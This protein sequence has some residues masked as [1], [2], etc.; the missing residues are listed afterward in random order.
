MAAAA[1]E[2]MRTTGG[3]PIVVKEREFWVSP[4]YSDLQFIGEGAYGMVV[5]AYDAYASKRV[6]IKRVS[7]FEHHTFCQ[8]TLREIKILLHFDHENIVKMNTVMTSA[9]LE[10]MK[11]VY[12][13][14]E[15]METDLHKVLKGLRKTGEKLS[16]THTCF[17]TYQMLL[18]LKYIHSANVLHRDLKPGNMLLNTTNC[19]LKICDFGLAR[20][21]DP[22]QDHAGML[23]EYVATRWYRAPEVMLNAKNY[24]AAL[25]MWSIGCILAEMLGNKAL[26]P[27]K[28]YVDQLSKI[29]EIM[30][31]PRGDDLLC[32]QSERPREYVLK[33]AFK[34]K[35]PLETLFPDAD[36]LA[37]DL[38]DRLLTFDP[39]RRF[40]AERALQHPYFAE[41]HDPED[42]PVCEEPFKFEVE[43]DNLPLD[44]LKLM[45]F[46]EIQGF[47]EQNPTA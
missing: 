39:S 24:T 37:L 5:S 19:D 16:S 45:M 11:D 28:N 18:A 27:G 7:P 44:E 30:G 36:P 4:R 1:L 25:D 33:L 35:I 22:E 3:P 12:L 8:R 46:K 43:F 38:L 20:V 14:L 32:I 41:Y 9:T 26:F 23:T 13:V 40:T 29:F 2:P 6:A 15:L 10:E 34:P 21:M 47:H 17:F 31:T 42:E